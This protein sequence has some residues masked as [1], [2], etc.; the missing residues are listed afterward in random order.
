MRVSKDGL[1]TGQ[2]YGFHFMGRKVPMT[3]LCIRLERDDASSLVNVPRA[4]PVTA[5]PRLNDPTTDRFASTVISA[6]TDE[7]RVERRCRI[8]REFQ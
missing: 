7:E 5:V 3:M 4:F 6:E 1:A 8:Q 2:I